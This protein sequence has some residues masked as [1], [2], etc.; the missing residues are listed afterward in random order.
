MV[1]DVGGAPV[2]LSMA[3]APRTRRPRQHAPHYPE[4]GTKFLS[5]AQLA[6]HLNVSVA[7]VR[8]MLKE[9]AIRG[10]VKVGQEWRIPL[11]RVERQYPST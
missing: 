8:L 2:L 7:K 5:T 6:V 11:A 9:G 10:A 4:A 3:T 1:S